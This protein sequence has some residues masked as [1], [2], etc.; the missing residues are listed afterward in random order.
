MKEYVK[1]NDN[2]EHLSLGNLFRLI[3]EESTMKN[4]FLQADLFCTL[5]DISDI[6]DSTVNNYCT[7]YRS[8]N[9][10]YKQIFVKKMHQY[11]QTPTIFVSTILKLVDT[12][13]DTL[14]PQT[15][16]D[17]QLLIINHNA[18][19]KEVCLR[20]YTL[21]KNDI[22]VDSAFSIDLKSQLDQKDYYSFMILILDF[23]ILK[24]KQPIYL[25]D[26]VSKLVESNLYHTNI[27]VREITDYMNVQ[28]Q[29]GILS[30]RSILELA[31]QENPFACF[32]L[33]SLEF[34]GWIAGKPR[35]IKSYEY[36]SIAA[37]KQHPVANWAIGFM[38]YHGYL[39]NKTH[40]DYRKALHYLNIS[41]KLDCS[42]AFNSLGQ[43]FLSGVIPHIPKNTKKALDYFELATT[44]NNVY[45]YNN[46]GLW[47]EKKDE[48]KKAFTFFQKSA[49]LGES[50]AAN[51]MGEYYRKGIGTK[52]DMKKAFD[53]Y[54]LSSE[55]PNY[56]VCMWSKYNLA[57]YVYQN[58]VSE[59]GISPNIQKAITLYEEASYSILEASKELIFLYYTQYLA[60]SKKDTY[61]LSK[62]DVYLKKIQSHPD[63][64]KK[65]GIEI[66]KLL[67]SLYDEYEISYKK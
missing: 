51:K 18:K 9:T 15:T 20:L 23:V 65:I 40:T 14:H 11:M 26:E 37:K 7:G 41:R 67:N 22:S 8:I 43:I 34:Y 45:A 29:N 61:L 27:S 64:T 13:E 56:C 5:F 38:Y 58:G 35:Y 57:K 24:K 4:S 31:K 66:E 54:L 1:L 42:H 6:S 39:G 16:L 48:I 62:I 44:K 53:Y 36:Y 2:E 49:D 3:K 12:L 52:K 55:A 19:L 59:L 28:L 47:Y 60:S 32:E 46:L 25:E 33:G 30:L 63:Y 21:S 17:D 10:I 50:W